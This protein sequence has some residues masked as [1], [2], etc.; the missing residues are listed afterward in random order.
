MRD[1]REKPDGREKQET[2]WTCHV[3]HACCTLRS[4][5]ASP[6][7][8]AFLASPESRACRAPCGHSSALSLTGPTRTHHKKFQSGGSATPYSRRPSLSTFCRGTPDCTNR[9]SQAAACSRSVINTRSN[10]HRL[11][12]SGEET[13]QERNV[14]RELP[15][16]NPTQSIF[17]SRSDR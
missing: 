16:M 5:P 15:S 9:S 1:E 10:C 11:I 14:S 7:P 3:Y 6:A 17:I 8:L 13:G 4:R 2:G 12:L